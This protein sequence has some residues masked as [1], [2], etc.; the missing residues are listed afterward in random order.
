RRSNY[1]ERD[2]LFNDEFNVMAQ[3]NLG[4][5][6]QGKIKTAYINCDVLLYEYDFPDLEGGGRYETGDGDIPKHTKSEYFIDSDSNIIKSAAQQTIGQEDDSLKKARLLYDFVVDSLEYDYSTLE[7]ERFGYNYASEII[8]EKTGICTDYSVLYAALCRASGIPAIIVQG[9]PVFSI[10]NEPD[11]ELAYGHSWVEIKLP[12]CGWI[13]VDVT[14]EEDFMGYN[15]FLNLQTYKGSGVFYK[16]LEID[17]ERYYPNG[18]YYTWKGSSGPQIEQDISYRVKG[19]KIEDLKVSRENGFLDE[20]GLILSEYNAA[21][22]HVKNAH[23]KDWIY[24]DPVEIA[25][26]DTLLK[27]LTEL[28]D[29]LKRING[30]SSFEYGHGE[31][32]RI[33]KDIIIAKQ[34]QINCMKSSDYNGCQS[35]NNIFGNSISKLFDCFNSMVDSYNEKY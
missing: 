31:L 4:R 2:R 23:K 1:Q 6:K 30:A 32:V 34:N 24:N 33:S 14:S 28:S 21:I 29:S 17:G 35:Y 22:N 3:F 8:Q 9:I 20:A 7:N 18:F 5:L 12:G 15:Y 25:I 16:S 11:Q 26:E 10:L 13:P 19:L 27:R